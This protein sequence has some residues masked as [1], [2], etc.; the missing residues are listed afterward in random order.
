MEV[1]EKSIGT[2]MRWNRKKLICCV[3]TLL[4]QSIG[5]QFFI[6]W[7]LIMVIQHH[8]NKQSAGQSIPQQVGR[9][10]FSVCSLLLLQEH[11]PCEKGN[12]AHIPVL[13]LSAEPEHLTERFTHSEKPAW[14]CCL[15]PCPLP[16][17]G[18]RTFF[19]QA[20]V[21]RGMNLLKVF[22][23]FLVLMF[24]KKKVSGNNV[25]ITTSTYQREWP[26][27]RSWKDQVRKYLNGQI[28]LNRTSLRKLIQKY[29]ES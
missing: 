7:G 27:L 12:G 28:L 13:V 2:C 10:R 8:L 20:H 11:W 29:L 23:V 14:K 4:I 18:F 21:W 24:T 9:E 6:V 1:V 3:I 19:G 15:R 5:T 22:N 17:M 26:Q 16:A 25:S